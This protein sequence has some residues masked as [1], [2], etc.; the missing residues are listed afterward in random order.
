MKYHFM[1]CN[2]IPIW[3]DLSFLFIFKNRNQPLHF[4]QFF[5][6]LDHSPFYLPCRK[7]IFV[8]IQNIFC[9]LA[10]FFCIL[11]N[12]H[13]MQKIKWGYWC[14]QRVIKVDSWRPD[15]ISQRVPWASLNLQ[16]S[17]FHSITFLKLFKRNANSLRKKFRPHCDS[18]QCVLPMVCC[19]HT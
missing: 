14:L 2:R 1:H 8:R 18:D 15:F 9:T 3:I 6:R 13:P 16:N 12:Y 4:N 7:L 17:L 5:A 10:A 11:K 19:A